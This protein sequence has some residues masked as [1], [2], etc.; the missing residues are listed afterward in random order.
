MP[1]HANSQNLDAE[2]SLISGFQA[3]VDILVS[4]INN[5]SDG[6]IIVSKQKSSCLGQ[7]EEGYIKF[8][9]LSGEKIFHEVS[10]V[11]TQIIQVLTLN[12][13][14]NGFA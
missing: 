3:L 14:V 8:V 4:L 5:D 7:I 10:S 13:H 2:G 9:M 6:R 12:I 11:S 1:A